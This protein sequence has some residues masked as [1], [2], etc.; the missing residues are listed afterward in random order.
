MKRLI[1]LALLIAGS[2]FGANI[3]LTTNNTATKA[4]GVH[5]FKN[6]TLCISGSTSGCVGL[7]VPAIAGTGTFNIGSG[8]ELSALSGLTS[9]ADK[10]P[11]FTGSGTAS[12]LTRSTD[13]TLA[14]NSDTNIPTQKAVKTYVDSQFA[15]AGTGDVVGPA[16]AVT[17]HVATFSS[18]TGKAIQDGGALAA[19]ATTDTTNASNISSGTLP[20]GR[21]PALTGDVTTSAGAVATTIANNAVTNAKAAQMAAHTFKGNNTG[22]TANASDL[23]ATQLTAELNAFVGDS[24]SGGTK[25]LVPAPATGDAA[26]GKFLKADGTFSV[27]PGTSGGGDMVKIAQVVTSS[28]AG[29]ITFSSIPGTYSNLKIFIMGRFSDSAGLLGLMMKVNSDATSGNYSPEQFLDGASGS[30]IASTDAA[31]SAG[32]VTGFMSGVSGLAAAI[33]ATEILIP[34]YAGTTFHKV[35]QFQSTAR[36]SGPVLRVRLGGFVWLSTSAIT[37]LDITPASG[38]TAFADGTTATLYGMN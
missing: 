18:T 28:S 10:I 20:A 7:T 24:G 25:G 38:A 30:A 1:L 3:T 6:S 27:P 16:S 36:T 19:S 5:S 21:M 33:S 2:A 26:A 12:L 15:A 11:Y 31:T 34:T 13:G 17:G 29:T 9:A 23:T 35:V 14:G 32:A 22:S 4:A 37:R 8:S